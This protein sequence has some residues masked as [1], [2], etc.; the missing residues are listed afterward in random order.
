MKRKQCSVAGRR[1]G[2][3]QQPS[4][5][6]FFAES[7][8]GGAGSLS[9]GERGPGG[10]TEGRDGGGG[11]RRHAAA[12]R[13]YAS[14]AASTAASS[15][16]SAV[17]RSS[18]PLV[19]V[20]KTARTRLMLATR[21]PASATSATATTLS[22]ASDPSDLYHASPDIQLPRKRIAAPAMHQS[23][24]DLGQRA[25]GLAVCKQCGLRFAAAAKEDGS[26][27]QRFHASFLGGIDYKGYANDT[28]VQDFLSDTKLI[29]VSYAIATHAQKLKCRD[30]LD[31]MNADLG[32]VSVSDDA[33][34]ACKLFLY[35]CKAKVVGA[36]LVEPI[37]KAYRLS[38][39]I[40]RHALP[41]RSFNADSGTYLDSGENIEKPRV[42]TLSTNLDSRQSPLSIAK[43]TVTHANDQEKEID[44]QSVDWMLTL[45]TSRIWVS[46][47]HR[48]KGIAV[49]MLD[50]CRRKFVF[51]CILD[52]EKMA[53]SQPTVAGLRLGWRYFGRRDFLV[54]T[55][56]V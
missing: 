55:L 5:A 16:A 20:A 32:A 34:K 21:S 14:T 19:S 53:F 25:A 17:R 44:Y 50:A 38:G 47:A 2:G 29:L 49:K 45:S 8:V 48:L 51:G 13:T 10:G 33:L 9:G 12:S 31:V 18:S 24:L 23:V 1:D 52:K 28:I 30:I 27:H 37:V 36:M 15:M 54:Y 4:V 46:K 43:L 35:V 42:L 56:G 39:P 3:G 11:S 6:S 26:L 7:G 41:N 22:S 40:S